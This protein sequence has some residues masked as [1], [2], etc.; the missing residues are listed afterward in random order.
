MAEITDK[1][2]KLVTLNIYLNP[3]DIFN[4]DLSKKV[5]IDGILFRINSIQ[6]YN[7]S[8]PSDCKVELLKINYLT[9]AES[10]IPAG[11]GFLLHDTGFYLLDSD[12][13]KIKFL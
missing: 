8:M 3:K 7:A 2:S 5:F 1:D 4:L 12:G 13:G 9:Y 10:I 6:D 11:S